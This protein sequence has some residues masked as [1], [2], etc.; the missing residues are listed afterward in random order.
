MGLS[1]QDF[2]CSYIIKIEG[3]NFAIKR[4]NEKE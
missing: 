3:C 4:L 2:T 1:M